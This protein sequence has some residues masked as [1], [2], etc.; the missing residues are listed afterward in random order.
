MYKR[1]CKTKTIKTQ[2]V[3]FWLKPFGSFECFIAQTKIP[4]PPDP[5]SFAPE[6][7]LS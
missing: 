7:I 2:I 1:I 6:V 3:P 4:R 5:G